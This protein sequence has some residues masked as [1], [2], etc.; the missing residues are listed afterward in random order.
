MKAYKVS[1]ADAVFRIKN[2]LFR[3]NAILQYR[4]ALRNGELT[5]RKLQELNWSKRKYIIDYAYHHIP[6]Y[7]EFYDKQGFN[8]SLLHTRDD[9][10]NVPVLEKECV[11]LNKEAMKNPT[12]RRAFFGVTKTGGSTGYPLETYIDKRVNGKSYPWPGFPDW[13]LYRR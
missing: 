4:L 8:P 6:F 10:A 13:C 9:W 11:R 2:I 1:F 7:K 12:V 5:D 3:R